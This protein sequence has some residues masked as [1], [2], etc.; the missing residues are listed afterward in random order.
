MSGLKTLVAGGAG[1]L[2]SHLCELLLD[3]GDEVWCLD[4]FVTGQHRNVARLDNRDRFHSIDHDIVDSDVPLPE[5]LE[6]DRIYN[7]ACPAGV[8]FYQAQPIKTVKTNIHGSLTLLELAREHD[9]R[10]FQ[11]STSEVYGDPEVHPQPEDYNGNV[12]TTGPRACYDEGKRCAEALFT[13]YH[14]K[15]DL[16]V[17]ICRIFNCYGPRTHLQDGRVVNTFVVEA[18]KGNPIPLHGEGEQTRSFCYVDDTVDAIHKLMEQPGGYVGPMNLG[19]P[20]EVTIRHLVDTVLEVTVSDAGIEQH[21]R[22]EDDPENRQPD[23]SYALETLDWEP[24]VPLKEGVRRTASYFDRV[25]EQDN[26]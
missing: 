24:S 15:Y 14:R 10:I 7:L 4:N 23:I 26:D 20:D 2:G 6:L 18:L 16:E 11:T 1:F 3:N 22:P 9:A 12:N 8:N 25:L 19:N 17:R 5:G 13:D 21:P